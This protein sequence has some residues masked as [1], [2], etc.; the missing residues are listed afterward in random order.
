M[1]VLNVERFAEPR[2]FCV[3]LSPL[4]HWHTRSLYVLSIISF[5]LDF[6]SGNLA[7]SWQSCKSWYYHQT[8][9]VLDNFGEVELGPG[10]AFAHMCWPG[11]WAEI[12]AIAEPQSWLTVR[13]VASFIPDFSKIQKKQRPHRMTFLKLMQQTATFGKK[14]LHLAQMHLN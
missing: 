10:P 9:T 8:S 4:V 6:V 5:F 12:V 14:T 11:T 13:S 2:P 7:L 1:S 3:A